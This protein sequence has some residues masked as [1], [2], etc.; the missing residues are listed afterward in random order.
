[1]NKKISFIVSGAVALAI[2]GGIASY[3]MVSDEEDVPVPE[4]HVIGERTGDELVFA[5]NLKPF[6]LKAMYGTDED[7]PLY[8]EDIEDFYIKSGG[9]LYLKLDD[10]V[11]SLYGIENFK[12][13]SNVTI[14]GGT[15]LTDWSELINFTRMESLSIVKSS[16][17][18]YYIRAYIAPL[19]NLKWLSISDESEHDTNRYDIDTNGL[20]DA[21]NTMTQLE[22]VSISCR[23]ISDGRALTNF[24]DKVVYINGY[25]I[26]ESTRVDTHEKLKNSVIY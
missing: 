17:N 26:D 3:A 1:M 9:S 15:A 22:T 14:S 13:F 12:R 16:I 8:K 19:H 2:L 11:T 25:R 18:A 21:I 20:L 24:R 6:V 10:S 4:D 5:N 7:R 23:N